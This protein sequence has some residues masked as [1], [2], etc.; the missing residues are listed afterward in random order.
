MSQ[1]AR[2]RRTDPCPAEGTHVL[3]G[4]PDLLVIAG[5]GSNYVVT[6]KDIRR[7]AGVDWSKI[8]PLPFPP[9]MNWN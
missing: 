4:T 1:P 9:T 8:A 2:P 3:S 5:D 7:A 6:A